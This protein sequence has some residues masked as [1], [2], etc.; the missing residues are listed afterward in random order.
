[1]LQAEQQHQQQHQLAFDLTHVVSDTRDSFI[2][3]AC[4]RAAFSLI[5]H[6][7]VWP[8]RKLLIVGPPSSGKTHLVRIWQQEHNAHVV[9]PTDIKGDVVM[10]AEKHR[11]LVIDDIDTYEHDAQIAL[12]HLYNAIQATRGW[13]LMTARR[14]V[15][16]WH[17][18]LPDL[19]SRMQS[20]PMATMDEPDDML[21]SRLLHKLFLDRQLYV[22]DN[23]VDFLVKRMDRRF[24]TAIDI[25]E[26]L[27]KAAL[28]T[29][30][31][32]NKVFVQQEFAT[33]CANAIEG[34]SE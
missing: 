1:M 33:M 22:T 23:V 6:T 14:F 12:F 19:I 20:V 13:L 11:H 2:V 30:R 18:H 34:D 32:L 21:L 27:D 15:R 10:L 24:S 5:N 16:D 4:N 28:A 26:Q 25:V 17:F 31:S 3:S 8:G 7:Q 9:T 29:G